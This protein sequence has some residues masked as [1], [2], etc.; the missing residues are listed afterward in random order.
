MQHDRTATMDAM[1]RTWLA[2]KVELVEGRGGYLWPR[3]G[4][5]FAAARSHTFAQLATAIDLAFGR[6]DLAPLH[7]FRLSD[8]TSIGVPDPD[9]P[10]HEALDDDMEL[11]RVRAGEAFAYE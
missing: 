9:W 2:I 10:G 3:P 11:S 8:G 7:G 1:A 5:V 6:W 4:R